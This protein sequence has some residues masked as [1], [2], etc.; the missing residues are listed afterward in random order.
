MEL[1]T[2]Y[3]V[4]R[5]LTREEWL[6]AR[7]G[8]QHHLHLARRQS[9]PNWRGLQFRQEAPPRE[10]RTAWS[11]LDF[12]HQRDV[13]ASE[14]EFALVHP[15]RQRAFFDAKRIEPRWCDDIPVLEGAYPWPNGSRS[16]MRPWLDPDVVLADEVADLLGI[17]VPQVRVW[18]RGGAFHGTKAGHHWRFSRQEIED[19]ARRVKGSLG[20]A[21]VA[22]ILGVTDKGVVFWIRNG[23]LPGCKV[24]GRYR[25]PAEEFRAWGGELAELLSANHATRLLGVSRYW[26]KKLIESGEIDAIADRVGAKFVDRSQVMAVA[27]RRKV[28]DDVETR[29]LGHH[30]SM[31]QDRPQS[32]RT[33]ARSLRCSPRTLRTLLQEGLLPGVSISDNGF[34]RFSPA[35]VEIAWGQIADKKARGRNATTHPRGRGLAL[36]APAQRLI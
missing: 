6:V 13:I 28:L 8:L 15:T 26:M 10:L 11:T 31:D 35:D 2:D 1:T 16:R 25:I 21:E 30:D 17:T 18:M 23:S 12:A 34:Y 29:S 20:T 32:L 36:R 24:A 3:F 19:V 4:H 33:V 22:E 5:K 27:S 9:D 14:L 7:D